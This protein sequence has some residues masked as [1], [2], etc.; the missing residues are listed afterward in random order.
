MQWTRRELEKLPLESLHVARNWSKADVTAGE[1]EENGQTLRFVVK[2]F[3]GRPLWYRLLGGRYFL[4]R[5][6][7]ALRA[8]DGVEGVPRAIARLD[9][10]AIVIGRLDGKRLDLYGHGDLP[11]TVL[12]KLIAMVRTLHERG[13]T[14]GD[15]HLQNVLVTDDGQVG[16]IDWATASV[17][18]PN[19]SGPR[20]WIFEELR[21]LD[22]RSLAKI[23]VYLWRDLLTAEDIDLIKNGASRAYRAV[24]S[25]RRVREKWAG[26][27]RKG[28]L[29]AILVDL[30]AKAANKR[31]G[32]EK[33]A[34]DANAHGAN[35]H[36]ANASDSKNG[37]G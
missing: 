8:M 20:R 13:V 16:L 36:G 6:W 9:A 5:E 35:A 37:R 11:E 26:K 3:G 28:H 4:R 2:D 1:I 24:K 22:V 10:D 7:N 29:D 17:Y 14:H 25:L 27:K 21:A 33:R 32:E 31:E 18:G 12:Q 23:K 15:L 34:T 19:L 30:E